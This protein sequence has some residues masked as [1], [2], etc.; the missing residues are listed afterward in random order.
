MTR[1]R[2]STNHYASDVTP[3]VTERAVLE[4]LDALLP[5]DSTTRARL[6]MDLY[7]SSLV[8]ASRLASALGRLRNKGWAERTSSERWRI[9]PKGR[10]VLRCSNEIDGGAA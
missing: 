5:W 2:A 10:D 9:T 6:H 1:L 8:G 4:A 7:G 3:L